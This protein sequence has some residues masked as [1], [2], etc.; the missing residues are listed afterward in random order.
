MNDDETWMRVAPLLAD[1]EV[2]IDFKEDNH[3]KN[4]QIDLANNSIHHCF[5]CEMK[6]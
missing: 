4:N 1:E 3:E 2:Q 6:I 5:V